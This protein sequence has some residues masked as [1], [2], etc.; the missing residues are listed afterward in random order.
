MTRNESN[1]TS[2]IGPVL[3][4]THTVPIVFV[5]VTD[6]VAGGFVES[7]HGRAAMLP[8]LRQQNGE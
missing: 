5:N 8:V 7:W 1:G 3:Q 4:T 6:P 2:T